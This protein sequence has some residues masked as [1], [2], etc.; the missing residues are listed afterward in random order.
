MRFDRVARWLGEMG[1]RCGEGGLLEYLLKCYFC[2]LSWPKLCY[3]IL[4]YLSH[5]IARINR[6]FSGACIYLCLCGINKI[7][8]RDMSGEWGRV[9]REREGGGREKARDNARAKVVYLT[10]CLNLL[11]WPTSA[12]FLCK[13]A[14]LYFGLLSANLIL[15]RLTHTLADTHEHTHT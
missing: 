1:A 6:V 4:L 13:S 9:W 15:S 14:D 5:L 8:L 10:V 12:L 7:T 11:L 2:Q 3:N